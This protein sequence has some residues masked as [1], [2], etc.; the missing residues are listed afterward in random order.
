[1]SESDTEEEAYRVA[2][3]H[4]S[5]GAGLMDS[6]MG[7]HLV[8]ISEKRLVVDHLATELAMWCTVRP[9]GIGFHGLNNRKFVPIQIDYLVQRA[10]TDPIAWRACQEITKALRDTERPIPPSL[11][12]LAL[13][14]FTGKEEEPSLRA[15][16]TNH[17]RDQMI[18]GAVQAVVRKTTL[19][20]TQNAAKKPGRR[21]TSACKVVSDCL[22]QEFGISPGESRVKEIWEKHVKSSSSAVWDS[23]EFANYV[24]DSVAKA[25]AQEVEK[26]L[27]S[28]VT[29]N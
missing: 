16:K 15:I 26:A 5:L 10:R 3:A 13:D 9:K 7:N 19:Q 29:E 11:I 8:N 2:R 1:M 25:A 12:K 22:Q 4:L 6:F 20:A 27:Q 24:L 23:S 14:I 17:L 28:F 21:S 18:G